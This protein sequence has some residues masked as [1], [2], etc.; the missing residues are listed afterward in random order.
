MRY[1][2]KKFGNKF[3][4]N[5]PYR[6]VIWFLFDVRDMSVCVQRKDLGSL[7]KNFNKINIIIKINNNKWLNEVL[8]RYNVSETY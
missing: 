7:R 3:G 1:R 6:E 2:L 8:V 5:R 4:M